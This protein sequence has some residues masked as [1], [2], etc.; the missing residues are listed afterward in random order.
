MSP[1]L[2]ERMPNLEA[3][4]DHIDAVNILKAPPAPKKSDLHDASEFDES[5]DKSTFRQFEDAEDRVKS[6]YAQAH[7]SDR[8]LQS[9]GSQ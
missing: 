4:S 8:R 5:K 9:Q 2:V 7:S 3:T 1:A 6:F